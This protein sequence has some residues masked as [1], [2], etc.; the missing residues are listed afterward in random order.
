MAASDLLSTLTKEQRAI[1]EAATLGHS[2]FITGAAGTG[3]SF[4]VKN[5]IKTLPEAGLVATSNTGISS[6]QLGGVTIHSFVGIGNSAASDSI[7]ITRVLN[8]KCAIERIKSTK[9]LLIDEGSMVKSLR[10]FELFNRI[11]QLIRTNSNHFGGMQVIFIADFCQLAPVPNPQDV[12]KYCF[13]SPL[14]SA[15][16]PS[17]HCFLITTTFRQNPAEFINLL[18]EVRLSPVLP[19]W[20]QN[21]LEQLAR[22]LEPMPGKQTPRLNYKVFSGML[23][24]IWVLEPNLRKN[25]KTGVKAKKLD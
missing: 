20:V 2:I 6:V 18:N 22:T 1:M 15:V 11:F 21:K 13:L 12:V 25:T 23:R 16:F 5:L 10:L 9:I 4:V 8:N 3:K 7:L 19:E 24:P 14:W 17:S